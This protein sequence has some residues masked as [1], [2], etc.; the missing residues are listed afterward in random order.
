MLNP[1][2]KTL[3]VFLI[4]VSLFSCSKFNRIQ[5][6]TDMEAKYK[7][8]VEYYES[9]GYFQALQLFEELVTLY[10]G[11]S[12][13][14]ATYYYYCMCYYQTGEFTVA[15]YHFNNFVRTFPGSE[16]AEQAA[17]NNAMCYY[18]DSP[19]Y[20]LDQ[21]STMEAINQ[22]QLFVN[23][24]PKSEKVDECNQLIDELRFKLEK[25][26]YRVAL[27]YYNME[28]YKSAMTAFKNMLKRYPS[29]EY[30]EQCL[31]HIM[32]SSFY[33]AERSIKTRQ[34]ERYKSTI[35]AHNE[36]VDSYPESKMAKEAEKVLK[37]CRERIK[38]LENED[39]LG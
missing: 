32:M 35:E 16:K 19:V 33:Y 25:K 9:G 34:S 20:S 39:N 11:T 38:K 13:A 30:E 1:T 27:L 4:S 23:R 10:R 17:F 3:L 14:E 18:L 15:A 21:T 36:F 22:F 8:A 28:K 29:T 12:K 31:Y 2:Y 26:E 37:E 6:S 24:Y 5:K 7:A